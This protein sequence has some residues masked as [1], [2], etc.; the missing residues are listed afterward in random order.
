MLCIKDIQ[1]DIKSQE[2]EIL[3]QWLKN[4]SRNQ[5]LYNQY[6]II[7]KLEQQI[8]IDENINK[9]IVWNELYD[10]IVKREQEKQYNYNAIITRIKNI[11]L[12]KYRRWAF[13]VCFLFLFLFVAISVQHYYFS[14]RTECI[15][16]RNKEKRIVVLP[17]QSKIILNYD[18]KLKYPRVF[19]GNERFVQLDG[20]AFFTVR[21]NNIPFI[22][23]SKNASIRV[24]GT[25]FNVWARENKTQVAVKN[26]QV[27][28]NTHKDNNDFVLLHKDQMSCVIEDQRP[29]EPENINI[30]IYLD[31]LEN[32]L[33]FDKTPLSEVIAEIERFYDV[34]IQLDEQ[35]KDR[36]L[37]AQFTDTSI[38][39]VL[40]K[41]CLVFHA[42]YSY[43]AKVYYITY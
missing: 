40:E 9:E 1:G 35:L 12:Y 23:R 26:G 39:L 4:S 20:E 3:T 2:K 29:Q 14:S 16:T 28:L 8:K 7:Q 36:L 21:K 17:D 19:N 15:A 43:D 33:I 38:E 10:K 37:T 11:P 31:W 5:E 24:L 25:E 42:K 34:T 32:L 41:I 6:K 18:S 30:A 22:L 13:A 27:R